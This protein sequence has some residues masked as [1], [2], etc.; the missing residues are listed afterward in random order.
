MLTRKGMAEVLYAMDILAS[1][2]DQGNRVEDW[3]KE[4]GLCGPSDSMRPTDAQLALYE[5]WL[6]G[7]GISN[8]QREAFENAVS[9]F[10]FMLGRE[11]FGRCEALDN[12]VCE[13]D[14]FG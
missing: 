6:M 9:T 5:G 13:E 14:V 1:K 7:H 3:E 10:V 4:T 8:E 2:L 11:A 12:L